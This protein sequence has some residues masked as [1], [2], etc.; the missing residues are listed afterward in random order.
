[1]SCG[2]CHVPEQG[3][4]NNE[5]ARPIGTEG[6]SLKRNAPGLFNVA[7]QESLFHDGRETALPG[8]HAIVLG[9]EGPGGSHAFALSAAL[10]ALGRV[11]LETEARTLAIEAALANGI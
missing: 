4:T 3:F 6:R 11:G 9:A 10:T 8:P 5:L 7:Y 2:I 1:M